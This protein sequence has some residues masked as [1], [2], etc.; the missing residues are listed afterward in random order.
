MIN[1]TIENTILLT[2]CT[3]FIV[4]FAKETGSFHVN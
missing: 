3:I 1:D 4:Y 2:K